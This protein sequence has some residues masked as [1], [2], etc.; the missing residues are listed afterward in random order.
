MAE[1]KIN[2]V[3]NRRVT[4]HNLTKLV[5]LSAVCVEAAGRKGAN[6]KKM[7]QVMKRKI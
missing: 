5:V 3:R 4:D 6:K 1:G 2:K 7:C